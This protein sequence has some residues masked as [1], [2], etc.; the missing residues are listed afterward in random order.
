MHGWRRSAGGVLTVCALVCAA[1]SASAGDPVADRKTL[2]EAKTLLTGPGEAVV[3]KGAQKCLDVGTPEAMALLLDVLD[4][5][6]PH[7]RDMVYE[8]MPRFTDPYARKL[9]ATKLRTS[10]TNARVKEWCAQ[11]LGAFGVADHV[12]ALATALPSGD[13]RVR[14]AAVRALGQIR[15]PDTWQ[16]VTS[17]AK[18][19]DPFVRSEVAEAA[20]RIDPARGKA[21]VWAALRDADAGV[22]CATLA[23]VPGVWPDLAEETAVAALADPDW[24]PRLQA[25]EN[26]AAIRTK[27][28]VDRTVEATGDPRPVVAAAAVA[29]MQALSGMR[30]TL[31]AQWEEWWRARREA[32]DFAAPPPA[33]SAPAGGSHTTASY[34]GLPVTSDHVAFIVDKSAD[35]LTSLKDGKTKDATAYAALEATLTAL[36]PGVVFDVF[37][38]GGRAQRLGKEPVPLDTKSRAAALEFVA[39][40]KCEGRKDIWEVLERVVSDPTLDTVYLLSSGEPEVGLYVHWNRVTEHLRILNRHHKVTI[41]GVSYT[42]SAWYRSQIENIAKATGGRFTARE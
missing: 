27:T 32:F 7:Y 30:F 42:A 10:S 26:L 15:D 8:F 33:A 14:A 22:R 13:A 29:R 36:D 37:T 17:L 24:R 38:Y 28:S 3:R 18:D 4:R 16:R 5:D 23:V 34:N 39:K 20:A 31:R 21:I 40:T 19:A 41:H 11:V 1:T 9:V 25:V 35:M 6:Q 12:G 2:A